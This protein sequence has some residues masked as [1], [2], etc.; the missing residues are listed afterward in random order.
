MWPHFQQKRKQDIGAGLNRSFLE[1]NHVKRGE[2]AHITTLQA[3]FTL[4]QE[5]FF[6]QHQGLHETLQNLAQELCEALI[7]G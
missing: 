1:G 2:N 6:K 3:L 7:Q 4:H 5:T